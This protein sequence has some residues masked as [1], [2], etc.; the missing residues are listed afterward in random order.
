MLNTLTYTTEIDRYMH[1]IT[2]E[3]RLK[4]SSCAK[5]HAHE[6]VKVIV[7]VET[8]EFIDFKTLK[9]VV[10]DIINT[11]LNGFNISYKLKIETTEQ[12]ANYI[13][14]E[15]ERCF[16]LFNDNPEYRPLVNVHIQ[17]TEKYGVST[18]RSR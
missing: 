9:Q 1:Q 7:S 17:E 11:H 15:T 6:N 10:E 8:D 18:C 5:P 4:D 13:A 3:P 12:L 16:S 2:H 14:D